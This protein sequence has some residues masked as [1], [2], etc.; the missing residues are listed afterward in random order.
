M[1]TFFNN[2]KDKFSAGLTLFLTVLFTYLGYRVIT[3]E[4]EIEDLQEDKAQNEAENAI[5][6]KQGEL[7]ATE[8][9]T[10][11]AEENAAKTD[12]RLNNS[13]ADLDKLRKGRPRD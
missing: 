3:Q 11:L 5:K 9:K 2:I 6:E 1:L 8:E 4:H 13:R 12:M 10:K 7:H